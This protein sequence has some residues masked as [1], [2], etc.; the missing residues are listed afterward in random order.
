MEGHALP[1]TPESRNRGTKAG[2]SRFLGADSA[3]PSNSCGG[4]LAERAENVTKNQC[5]NP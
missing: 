2:L 3:A 4:R 5:V 1:A